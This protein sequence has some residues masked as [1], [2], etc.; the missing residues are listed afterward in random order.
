M[1]YGAINYEFKVCVFKLNPE[2]EVINLLAN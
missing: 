1:N 2:N